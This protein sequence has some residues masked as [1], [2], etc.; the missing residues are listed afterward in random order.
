MLSP[1]KRYTTLLLL[2]MLGCCATRAQQNPVPAPPQKKSVLIMNGVAHI[3]NGQ[4]I[5]NAAI[6]FREGK[7]DLVADARTIRLS[8]NAYDTVIEASG[9]HIYPGFIACNSTLGLHEIDAVRAFNDVAEVGSFKPSV[10][11][12]IAY[13][14][15]SEILPTVRSNGVLLAQITPRGGTISGVSSVM[16]LDAWNWEDALIKEDDGIHLNWPQV[17]HRHSD[18]GKQTIERVKTYDQQLREIE[19]FFTEARAYFASGSAHT[20]V[21]FEAL[22]GVVNG[23][24]NLY[25]HADEARA[26][27]EALNFKTRLK[28][29]KVVIVGGYDSWLVA[30]ELKTSG[31]PVMLRR[32]HGL[33]WYEDD[34]L[35]LNF[36]LPGR[37]HEAGVT[38]C[39]QNEGDMERANTRN[40]PFQA[41]T[42][43]AY[44]LPYEEAV[45]AITLTPATILGI[46][47]SCGSLE[48]GKDATLFISRGDALDMMTNQLTHAFIQGRSIDLSSKQTELYLKYKQKYDAE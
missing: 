36:A 27:L 8:A 1:M 22:R 30:D 14:T 25:V 5:D 37:L 13:N 31:V 48:D 12:A 20:E 2:I 43:V 26:I 44:G 47:A 4:V 17:F 32:V 42:C 18:K 7:L 38:F 16:Q 10:R 19:L 45:K 41:G 6:G 39:I 11:S 3:G 34:D 29:P 23:T 35:D 40:L 15:D 46:S 33:P 24:Q 9:M 21:R 28:I